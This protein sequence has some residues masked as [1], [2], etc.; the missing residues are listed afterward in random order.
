[1]IKLSNE[2]AQRMLFYLRDNQVYL[3]DLEE[4]DQ[5]LQKAENELICELELALRA[6]SRTRIPHVILLE[7]A[8]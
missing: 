6:T 7:V 1:M 2:T 8:P 3:S 5:P 4:W